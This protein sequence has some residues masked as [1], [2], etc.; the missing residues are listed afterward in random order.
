MIFKYKQ[1]EL[2][3]NCLSNFL[4]CQQ[5][6]IFFVF[7]GGMVVWGGRI[8]CMF[9]RFSFCPVVWFN[10]C[11]MWNTCK[12]A[13]SETSSS[14]HEAE[15]KTFK[16]LCWFRC[17]TSLLGDSSWFS[18]SSSYPSCRLASENFDRRCMSKHITTEVPTLLLRH[19]IRE[20]LGGSYDYQ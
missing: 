4:R 20:S 6:M 16:S 17:N 19:P 2:N 18:L 14:N 3:K 13:S 1:V 9:R 8:S 10:H 5:M 12:V 7:F 11:P 15:S